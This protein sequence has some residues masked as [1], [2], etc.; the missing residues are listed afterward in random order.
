MR[1]SG[2][3]CAGDNPHMAGI[4]TSMRTTSARLID[5]LEEL[6]RLVN[7]ERRDRT[8]DMGRTLEPVRDLL[9]RLGNPH[10]APR[11][12]HVA[13]TKGKGSVAA[14]VAAALS[15]AGVRCGCYASPHVERVTERVRVGAEEVEEEVLAHALELAL[16]HREQ[17]IDTLGV[18]QLPHDEDAVFLPVALDVHR[19]PR[20]AASRSR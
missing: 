10:L 12:V 1:V 17:A 13:G 14:I 16:S 6:D 3:S 15:A 8:A 19:G 18:E 4:D 20:G 7:W 2:T 11:V 9:T 5:V